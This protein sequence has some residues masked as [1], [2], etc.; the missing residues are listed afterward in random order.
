MIKL[1][2]AQAWVKSAVDGN[3]RS[4]RELS[5]LVWKHLGLSKDDSSLINKIIKGRRGVSADELRAI[6]YITG[7]P[8]PPELSLGMI[9]VPIIPWAHVAKLA[10]LSTAL[11]VN[12]G[13]WTAFADLGAG[14]FFAVQIKGDAMD[15]VSP[16]GS[17]VVVNRSDR[18]LL[19]ECFYLAE[20]RGQVVYRQWQTSPPALV[21]ASIKGTQ[22][23]IYLNRAQ[24]VTVIGRVRRTVLDL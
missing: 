10:D 13:D 6:A 8:I 12:S 16:N 4:D 3:E 2:P 20:V 11:P 21:P 1:T 5:R 18:K 9:R 15:R 14:D 19:K 23:M 17:L 22:K 7:H 24:D